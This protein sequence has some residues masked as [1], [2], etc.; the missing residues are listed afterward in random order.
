[1]CGVSNVALLSHSRLSN[2]EVA[3]DRNLSLARYSC[4][5]SRSNPTPRVKHRDQRRKKP[6]PRLTTFGATRR[7]LQRELRTQ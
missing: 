2:I 4:V 7:L 3:V 5:I 1:M 6:G